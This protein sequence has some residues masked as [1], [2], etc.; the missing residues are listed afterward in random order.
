M[1]QEAAG[2][3]AFFL[4]DGVI[5]LGAA[6]VFVMTF[7]RLGLGAV[8]GY[9][10]AGALIGPQGLGLITGADEMLHVADFGIVLL[11]FLV[12]LELQPARLLRLRNDILGLRLLQVTLAGVG[13]TCVSHLALGCTPL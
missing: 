3:T 9:L 12:G 7:R 5:I 11:L 2:A 13:F 10:L 8:L 6:M 1:G 4:R